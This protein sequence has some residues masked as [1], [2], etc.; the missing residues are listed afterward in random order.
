MRRV[1]A[2]D[3]GI[4]PAFKDLEK[5]SDAMIMST[6]QWAQLANYLLM[7]DQIV[8]PTGNLQI[9]PVLRLMLGEEVFDELIQTKGIVLARYDQWL[10]YAG[11]GGGLNFFT[12]HDNPD[13][14]RQGPNIF[15]SY[16]KPVDE[17]IDVALSITKPSSTSQ[18][19]SE[20]KNLLMDNIVLL[21]TQQFAD[22]I[23]DEAYQDILNSPYLR[24]FL[25]LRNAGR[26]LDNLVGL[27]PNKLT[28]FNPH[29][30]AGADDVPEIRSVLR[31]AFENLLLRIGS[32][33]E[34]TDVTGDKTTLNILRAKGQR[35]GF[36]PEGPHAF[37]Q[38]QKVA[39]VPDIGQ[40]FAGKRISANQLL[41]L[42]YSTHCQ[43]FRDWLATSSPGDQA[44]EIVRKYVD[45]LG[46]PYWLE[47]IPVKLMR[48]ASTTGIGVLE[49][50]SGAATS[51]IDN[52][53]LS[54][55]FPTR[56]PRI[57]LKQAKI[58][59]ASAPVIQKP[60]MKGRKRNQLCPC[61]SGKKYKYCCGRT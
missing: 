26:S 27:G 9:L 21:P 10:G 35:V 46:K 6:E 11:N 56:S 53:L 61:G 48:F 43:A 16:F 20:L 24:E 54:K 7:Y 29:I 25:S 8:I 57:F 5:I 31:V 12:V 42:R 23:K 49:P 55:W 17:A 36:S 44:D 4:W 32:H 15:S 60:V 59:L 19:Q 58:M 3:F 40:A 37:T 14:P 30:P 52:F 1:L 41:E 28:T 51:A 18:R 39:G 13:I 38:I 47:S 22:T 45:S 50:I 33:A 34:V 2:T